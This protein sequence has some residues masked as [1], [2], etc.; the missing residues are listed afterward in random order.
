MPWAL[1]MAAV[2]A[3]ALVYALFMASSK[4]PADGYARYAQGAMSKLEVVADAPDQP[5]QALQDANGQTTSLAAYRGQ[6]VLVNLWA[7]WCAPCVEEMPTLGALQ[8]QFE[9]RGFQVVPVSIDEAA[10]ADDAKEMLARLSEN[11]LPFLIDPSRGIAFEA[12]AAGVPMSIL[13]DRSGAEIARLG[14]SADWN[15]PEAIALI[16]AALAGE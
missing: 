14:G 16:E 7:T 2:G 8:R 1:G 4:P 15:A 5:G 3:G 12:R 13:Y 10:K 6:V 9:G 11:A